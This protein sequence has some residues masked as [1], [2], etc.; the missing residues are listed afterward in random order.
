MMSF[1]PPKK[2]RPVFTILLKIPLKFMFIWVKVELPHGF[3]YK[4]R[5]IFM[6]NHVSLIDSPLMAAYIPQFINAL[7]AK[8]HFSWPIYGKLVAQWG[9]IPI[10]RK[11]IRASFNS[12]KEAGQ[13]VNESNSIIV[14]PEGGRTSNGE[15]MRFKKMP[16]HLAKEAEVAIIPVGVSGIFSV[17]PK[18]T[19]LLR[20]GK[21]LLKLGAPIPVE[22]VKLLSTEE[23]MEETRAKVL[24]LIEYI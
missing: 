1:I 23:L 16:F 8:E 3:D 7:E 21:V 14:F 20:P 18:G 12:I 22:R 13:R 6:P 15:L 2:F 19:W 9:N 10:D 5:Y 17:N 4:G 24:D 11:S